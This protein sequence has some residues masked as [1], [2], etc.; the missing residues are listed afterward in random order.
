MADP[1]RDPDIA[2]A[3]EPGRGSPPGTPRWVK[4]FGLIGIILV[5]L[6]V[7]GL[8]TGRHHGPGRHFPGRNAPAG[9]AGSETSPQDG[10][11]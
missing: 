6:F 10:Q 11:R 3:V 2:A 4:V 9:N 8:L 5:M 7:L 1:P